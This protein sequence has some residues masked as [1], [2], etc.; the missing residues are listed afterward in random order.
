MT[1]TKTRTFH[2]L[3]QY[4]TFEARLEYLRLGGGV[5]R[6]TFGFDRYIN[7]KFYQSFEWKQVRNLV[8]VRDKGCDLGIPGFEIHVEPL[9]HHMNPMSV[10]DIIRRP[11]LVLDPNYLITTT[12]NTH[13]AIHYGGRSPY[14]KVVTQRT[15]NDTKLW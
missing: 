4:E 8:L 2:E 3:L 6:S 9:I 13:N 15:P 14:P 12:H 7:Q 10:E 11:E 5:G 1:L